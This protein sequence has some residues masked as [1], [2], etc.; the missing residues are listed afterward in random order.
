MKNYFNISVDVVRHQRDDT[1]LRV[2]HAPHTVRKIPSLLGL[3]LL[4]QL[5]LLGL[6]LKQLLLLLSQV[7]I[8][9]FQELAFLTQASQF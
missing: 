3:D 5:P 4:L 1:A 2:S 8:S 9:A 7:I 6:S